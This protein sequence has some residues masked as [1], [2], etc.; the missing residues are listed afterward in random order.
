MQDRTAAQRR[1]QE[2]RSASAGVLRCLDGFGR[3]YPSAMRQGQ[4][5]GGAAGRV[6]QAA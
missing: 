2:V 5:S 6:R 1:L 3:A 4:D